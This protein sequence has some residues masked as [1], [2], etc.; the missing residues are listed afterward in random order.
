VFQVQFASRVVEA[1][2]LYLM[3]R[4][5]IEHDGDR[6]KVRMA[7]ESLYENLKIIGVQ[8]QHRPVASTR[9]SPP[10]PPR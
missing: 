5:A 1:E 9:S 3:A 4:S 2:A 10:G 6:E 8:R 7:L